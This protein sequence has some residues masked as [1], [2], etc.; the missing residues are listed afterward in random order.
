MEFMD[1]SFLLDTEYA[2][3]LYHRFAEHMPIIDYH[4]HIP[5]EEI[6]KDVHF[7]SITELWLGAD[8]YK[9]RLMRGNGVSESLITGNASDY[10][11]FLAF[12]QALQR[13]PGNPLYHW[14]HLELQRYFDINEPLTA[15]NARDIYDRCNAYLQKPGFSARNL[16][17]TIPVM[18]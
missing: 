17:K 15:S 12:A 14:S 3:T 13:A 4:C 5:V 7:R 18:I 6:A 9:W 16:I 11:K 8:H 1:R 10:A 2:E